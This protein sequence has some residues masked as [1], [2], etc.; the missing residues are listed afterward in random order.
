MVAITMEQHLPFKAIPYEQATVEVQQI[1]DETKRALG[2][3]FV[4]NWF[5]CQGG[6]PLLL[7]GNWTKLRATL[8]EGVVPNIIKQLIIYNVSAQRGCQ[9]CAKAH[10]VFANTMGKSFGEN[11][12]ITQNLD[13]DLIPLSY[14]TAVKVVTKAALHSASITTTDFQQLTDVGFNQSEIQEL[15]A[16]ADLV[17]MLNTI[18]DISGI[19]IDNELLE[20]DT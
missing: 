11:F 13:S 20:I 8:I 10:A 12:I 19:K 6:N 7:Q 15:M 14:R 16:Q 17:N 1:Y 4:L 3:P 18:A 5:T 2:L 9:Y